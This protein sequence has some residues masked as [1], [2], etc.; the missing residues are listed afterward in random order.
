MVLSNY[1]KKEEGGLPGFDK[2]NIEERMKKLRFARRESHAVDKDT[3]WFKKVNQV[4]KAGLTE[5][6]EKQIQKEMIPHFIQKQNELKPEYE[7]LKTVGK[8][9]KSIQQ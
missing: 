1:D 9:L 6:D 3:N 2:L 7:L 8:E 5:E 4:A